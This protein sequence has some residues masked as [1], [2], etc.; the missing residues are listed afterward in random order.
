[1]KITRS[2]IRKIIT[3]LGVG[4]TTTGDYYED[5][6]Q[7]EIEDLYQEDLDTLSD[8]VGRYGAVDMQRLL[9]D[10]KKERHLQRYSFD[11]I[12]DMLASL[13]RDGEID[14]DEESM[15]WVTI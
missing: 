13:Q 9:G 5:R 10:V 14:Y 4:V 2:Q 3:E 8:L 12:K 6:R 1:M 7:E 15:Q 11:D